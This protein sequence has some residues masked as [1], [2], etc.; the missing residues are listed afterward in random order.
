MLLRLVF[1]AV[2][3]ERFLADALAHE[4]Q[5]P[6]LTRWQVDREVLLNDWTTAC[7][8]PASLKRQGAFVA[9]S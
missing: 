8:V 5:D 4:L 7:S 1:A 9:F 6:S 2:S 3:E